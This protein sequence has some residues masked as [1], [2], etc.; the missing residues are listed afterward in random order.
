MFV[1]VLSKPES[2]IKKWEEK[3]NKYSEHLGKSFNNV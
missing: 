3:S 1:K 2:K